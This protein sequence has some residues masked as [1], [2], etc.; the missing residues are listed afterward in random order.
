ME[1][2]DQELSPTAYCSPLRVWCRLCWHSLPVGSVLFWQEGNQARGTLNPYIL[3]SEHKVTWKTNVWLLWTPCC[4]RDDSPPWCTSNTRQRI[5][6]VR[7]TWHKLC[8]RCF[9]PKKSSLKYYVTKFSFMQCRWWLTQF[10]RG[11]VCWGLQTRTNLYTRLDSAY[12]D[13]SSGI[14]IGPRHLQ[15]MPNSSPYT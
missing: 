4:L 13:I 1:T 7:D 3:A 5:N 10:P 6:Q 12:A 14:S 11:A 8:T 9:S 2:K 15:Y